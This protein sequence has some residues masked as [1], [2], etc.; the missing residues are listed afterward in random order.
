MEFAYNTSYQSTIGTTQFQLM[1]GFP[2]DSTGFQPKAQRDSIHLFADKAARLTE[3]ARQQ[4]AAVRHSELQKAQQ[5]HAFDKHAQIHNFS[6]N[7]Q[8]L[9]RVHDFLN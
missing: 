1:H 3:L 2:A 9:V 7:Q 6:L 5:K 4:P 8:V